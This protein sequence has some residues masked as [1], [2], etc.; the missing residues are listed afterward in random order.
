MLYQPRVS[1]SSLKKAQA[2]EHIIN[3]ELKPNLSQ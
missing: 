3:K 1:Y 2:W